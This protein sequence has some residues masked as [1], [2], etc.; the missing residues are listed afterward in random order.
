MANRWPRTPLGF[1]L[2]SRQNLYTFSFQNEGHMY[3]IARRLAR[4]RS[5]RGFS[6]AE[7]LVGGLV[8]V[9]GMVFIAQFFAS[10]ASRVLDSDIRSVL[11]QVATE[12]LETIRGMP[13][14]DV[15]TTDG[16]PEGTLAPDED[17]VV[18]NVTIH[19]HRDVIYWTDDSYEGPYP[20]NYRRVTVTVSAVGRQGI[21][22]VELVSN[23]AGGAEGGTLDIT[24][25]DVTGDPVEGAAIRITNT[26]LVPNVDIHSAALKTNNLGRMIVPGLEPDPTPSYVVTVSKSGYN[27]DF[28]DPAVVV[29]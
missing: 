16:H 1:G 27:T 2:K 3:R 20:A 25:T 19:I 12:D 22:P 10:A 4:L 8:L 6:L 29:L 23:V 17:R 7:V 5:Q 15:G 9:V 21:Q 11:H 24:V 14:P 28:T 13:Y 18:Q 26:N